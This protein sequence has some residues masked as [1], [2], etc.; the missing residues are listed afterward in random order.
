MIESL[1]SENKIP[2]NN[3]D[4][5]TTTVDCRTLLEFR[6]T[7]S[8]NLKAALMEKLRGLILLRGSDPDAAASPTAAT[9]ARAA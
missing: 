7:L 1:L 3:R 4:P 5:T 9:R 8:H 2:N 6:N